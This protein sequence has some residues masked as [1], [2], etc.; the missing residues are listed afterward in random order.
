M[1]ILYGFVGRPAIPLCDF[2]KPGI[3]GN[4]SAVVSVLS[5]K[6]S[7]ADGTVSYLYEPYT[8]HCLTSSSL[9]FVCLTTQSFSRSVAFQF[10][11]EVRSRFLACYLPSLQSAAASPAAALCFPSSFSIPSALQADF[12]GELSRLL[13]KYSTDDA[14]M[15]RMRD[16]L[17]DT[18]DTMLSNLDSVMQRGERLELLEVKTAA[19]DQH[20]LRFKTSSWELQRSLWWSNA[21]LSL[22][23]VCA[24]T[25]GL[26]LLLAMA[27]GGL[28]LPQC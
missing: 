16:D 14:R 1:P 25:G 3:T 19:L 27:C 24:A 18:T 21:R 11:A 7:V 22:V 8:F 13:A 20:A 12:E 6:L 2:T 28:S 23:S 26:Y 10:L 4:F 15:Q 5:K 9:Q 17:A